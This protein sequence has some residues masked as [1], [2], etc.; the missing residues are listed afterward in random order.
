[1]TLY[2]THTDTCSLSKPIRSAGRPISTS[3][4][5]LACLACARSGSKPRAR[6]QCKSTICGL[7]GHRSSYVISLFKVPYKSTIQISRKFSRAFYRDLREFRYL[8]LIRASVSYTREPMKPESRPS[9][10]QAL[11][12]AVYLARPLITSS[13]RHPWLSTPLFSGSLVAEVSSLCISSACLIT[14][15]FPQPNREKASCKKLPKR[16]SESTS[17]HCE[18][19]GTRR[20]D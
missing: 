10:E 2:L 8:R 3:N 11:A 9:S 4:P 20:P 14:L 12:S 13:P 16:Q 7:N 15:D 17:F 5:P 1:L 18:P 6:L 19:R